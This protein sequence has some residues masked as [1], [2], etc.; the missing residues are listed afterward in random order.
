M[1]RPLSAEAR[2]KI[3]SAA[4][5]ILL[6]TGV[7]GFTVDAVVRRSG[8]AKTTIYRH[9]DNSAQL[10][11]NALDSVVAPFPTPNTGSLRGDLDAY[12][13]ITSQIT[14]DARLRLLM[15][16]LIA[17]AAQNQELAEVKRAMFSERMGP[18]RTVI[19]LAMARGEISSDLDPDLAVELAEAPFL[20]HL[21]IHALEPPSDSQ[22]EKMIE[23][24]V[25]GLS[26]MGSEAAD[27]SS[28]SQ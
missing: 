14:C 1:A 7:S 25:A 16:E 20:S 19:Q 18:V 4:G 8:V 9:F 12:C 23:F 24:V 10:I 28:Q 21:M 5:E 22:L 15:L 13:K 3:L 26:G 17:A 6:D 11:L 2:D 27:P